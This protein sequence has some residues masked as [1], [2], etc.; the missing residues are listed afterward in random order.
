MSDT[1]QDIAEAAHALTDARQHLE[2]RWEWDANRNR[3]PLPPH[4]TTVPGLIQQ[5]RDHAEPGV[6]GDQ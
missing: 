3:K 5:L 4:R 2:P 1:L 6:D